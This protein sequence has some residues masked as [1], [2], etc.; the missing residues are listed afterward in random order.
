MKKTLCLAD[1]KGNEEYTIFAMFRK[2][3]LDVAVKQ[4]NEK[5]DLRI[6]YQ[7]EKVGRA[8]KILFSLSNHK[9]RPRR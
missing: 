2:K 8:F 3:V 1:D 4:I 9:S 7:V 6:G 5:T